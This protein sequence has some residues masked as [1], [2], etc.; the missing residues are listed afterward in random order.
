MKKVLSILLVALLTMVFSVSAFAEVKEF[1][2][3]TSLASSDAIPRAYQWFAD[4]LKERSNGTLVGTCYNEC[5]LGAQGDY[6][7]SLQLDSIQIAESSTSLLGNIDNQFMI[8][9]IPYVSASVEDCQAK[10]DAGLGDMLSKSLEEKCGIVIIGWTIRTPRNVYA[11]T[12]PI[13]TIEDFKG[14]VIR[15]M[16]TKPVM[17]AFELLGATP[18]FIS[19]TERYMALQTGVVDAAENSSAEILV[20]KEYEVTDYLSLTEHLIVPNPMC[21]SASWFY[22]LTEEEQQLVR[23]IGYEAGLLG[24]KYEVEALAEVEAELV[25]IGMKINTISSE[26]KQKIRDAVAPMYESYLDIIG[27]GVWA[28][29]K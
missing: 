26:E 1:S 18:V 19:G 21:V 16:D 23:E 4:E 29:F 5:Q 12:R 11:S 15:T 14:M 2:I 17:T 8:F 10:L 9:D 27:D 25:E 24:T 6:I 7:T 13:N 28:Y 22:S 20:K 3:A